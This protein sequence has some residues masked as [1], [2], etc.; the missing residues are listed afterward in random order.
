MA[1]S[2]VYY[3]I[4]IV[5]R[6]VPIFSF[7]V[8]GVFFLL[9]IYFLINDKEKAKRTLIAIGLLFISGFILIVLDY[10][11]DD[12]RYHTL[13]SRLSTELVFTMGI[14][15]LRI[16]IYLAEL[17]S[18]SPTLGVLLGAFTV[19]ISPIL[20]VLMYIYIFRYISKGIQVFKRTMVPASSTNSTSISTQSSV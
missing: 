20:T 15:P 16:S 10:M 3:L 4:Y 2:F 9:F 13:T 5:Q 8:L 1:E 11:G 17:F 19:F 12:Y 18:G 14:L 7:L 6:F